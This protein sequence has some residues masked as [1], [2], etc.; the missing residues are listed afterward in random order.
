M[1]GHQVFSNQHF[2]FSLL[3]SSNSNSFD[4][5]EEKN[6]EINRNHIKGISSQ[7]HFRN[8]TLP[9]YIPLNSYSFHFAFDAVIHSFTSQFNLILILIKKSHKNG[10]K[11]VSS[12]HRKN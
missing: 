10:W 8:S 5:I 2:N 6:K 7:K 12:F 9:T 4:K 1:A 11:L 3:C